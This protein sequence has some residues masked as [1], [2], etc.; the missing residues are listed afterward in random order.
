MGEGPA[1]SLTLELADAGCW[2]RLEPRLPAGMGIGTAGVAG[3]EDTSDLRGLD[4]SDCVRECF[5]LKMPVPPPSEF[6]DTLS[7]RLDRSL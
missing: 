6:F 7:V 4:T 5:G 2:R 1:F 3:T